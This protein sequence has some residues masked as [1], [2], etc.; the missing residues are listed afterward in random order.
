MIFNLQEE[1][2]NKDKRIRELEY[3]LSQLPNNNNIENIIEIAVKETNDLW[4]ER[5]EQVILKYKNLI[6][7]YQIK[8][9]ELNNIINNNK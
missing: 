1:L 2:K 7:S 8:I 5:I 4:K 6:L 3:Q 9:N